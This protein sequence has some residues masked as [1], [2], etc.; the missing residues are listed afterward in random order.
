MKRILA[1]WIT[2]Y[3]MLLGCRTSASAFEWKPLN[4]E[5]VDQSENDTQ[6][7]VVLKD[8]QNHTFK[9]IYQDEIMLKKL[10]A[11][12]IKYKDIFYSWQSIHCKN[13]TFMVIA[14]LLDVVIIP[15]QFMY[16]N[17]NIASVIPAGITM[18]YD[19]D[20]DLLRYDFRI[21]SGDRFIRVNGNYSHEEELVNKTGLA[22]DDP[23]S[24]LQPADHADIER[25]VP[26]EINEKMVQALIYL[27][28]EDWLGRQKTLPID[29]IHKVVELKKANPESSKI[30]L[31]QLVKK[32]KIKITKREFEFILILYFIEFD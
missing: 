22:Y 7:I 11:P 1:I 28:N 26:D 24:Y 29:T 31:W 21:I 2:A 6:K 9:V 10:S 19:P 15:G 18:T 12:I 5:L 8:K 32:E 13:L 3:I 4:V 30:Q 17:Q 25:M 20:M 27:N 16:H 23:K 14:N